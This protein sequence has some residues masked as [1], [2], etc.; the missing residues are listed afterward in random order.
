VIARYVNVKRQRMLCI[1]LPQG[2][3]STNL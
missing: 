3:Y 2:P 1:G